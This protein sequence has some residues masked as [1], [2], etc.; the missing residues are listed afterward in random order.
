M[1]VD[2][3]NYSVVI[4]ITGLSGAGKTTLGREVAQLFRDDGRPVVLLDGDVLREILGNDLGH[5]PAAR[6]KNAYRLSAMCKFLSEQRISVVCATMSLYPEIWAWNRS[7]LRNYIMVYLKVPLTTLEHRD[8]KG[9]YAK[10]R[11]G[12]ISN[13]FGIDLPFTEPSDPDVVVENGDT[14]RQGQ[15]EIA[16]RLYILTKTSNTSSS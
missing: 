14:D 9:I 7:H 4:W 8:P 15:L 2:S 5:D 13:V 16:N 6:L 3:E 1:Q 11:S 12:E 10:A